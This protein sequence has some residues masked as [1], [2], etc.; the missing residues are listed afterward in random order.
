MK[1]FLRIVLLCCIF[2]ALP[3]NADKDSLRTQDDSFN[4]PKAISAAEIKNGSLNHY[5]IGDP[6]PGNEKYPLLYAQPRFYIEVTARNINTK[7]S[8]HFK[9]AQF[10]CKQKAAF[11]KYLVLQPRLL[12]LLE[13][14]VGAVRAAGYPVKTFGVI[15]GYRT[16][17]YNKKIGNVANSRHT[18]GDAMDFFI[19]VDGDGRMDDLNKD[20]RHNKQDVDLLYKIVDSFKRR[21]ENAHLIGGVGRYYK[22]SNHGGFIHVDTR[23][24][25]ARW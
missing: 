8:P 6:P 4:L 13:G 10:V 24:Y 25:R 15:S 22:T 3:V 12:E 20:G 23:G 11:P 14:L 2:A 7:V 1:F 16:P 21:S 18:Y 17:F 9:L 5:R 19:D